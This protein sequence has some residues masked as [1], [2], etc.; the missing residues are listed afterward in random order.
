MRYDDIGGTDRKTL[1]YN[2]IR[3]SSR[4]Y[5]KLNTF[6]PRQ[7][8]VIQHDTEQKLS[9]MNEITQQTIFQQSMLIPN[10]KPQLLQSSTRSIKGMQKERGHVYK[11]GQGS[12]LVDVSTIA[13]DTIALLEAINK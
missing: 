9:E 13:E 10:C 2:D 7:P 6:H 3:H 1:E 12:C 8:M 5:S 4:I 11:L